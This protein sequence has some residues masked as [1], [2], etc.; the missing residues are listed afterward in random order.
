MQDVLDN[1]IE[2][3]ENELSELGNKDSPTGYPKSPTKD[4]QYKFF[5]DI[6][7]L[8]DTTRIANLSKNELGE[9]LIGVRHYKEIAA[10][11]EAEGL[12]K[13]AE[14]IN[15]KANIVTSTSMS[16]KGFWS[17]LFM[18]QIKKE[19]KAKQTEEVNKKWFHKKTGEES[20][21]QS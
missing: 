14:Y 11:A 15:G 21:E 9:S 4:N 10:Y 8:V 5:R 6:I 3:L 7:R 2:Q 1:E 20:G 13:V 16:K 18:T 12:D 17:E 19:K